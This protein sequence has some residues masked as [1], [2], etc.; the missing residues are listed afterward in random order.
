MFNPSNYSTAEQTPGNLV[1]TARGSSLFG[2]GWLIG[3]PLGALLIAFL[4]AGSVRRLY[5][6]N[7][8][9]YPSA[10]VESPDAKVRFFYR[11]FP[12]IGIGA[13]ALF[14]GIGYTSGSITLNR[15]TNTATMTGKMTAF[16]PAQHRTVALDSI[17][18]ATL[19]Q[20]PNSRRIRLEGTHGQD[21]AFPI[22]SDRA[23]QQEAVDAINRFLQNGSKERQP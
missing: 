21:L 8:V 3:I 18:D 16:L 10:T 1:V 5:A 15:S 12:A 11:L 2:P 23:G 22:W 17:T 13:A 20:K 14:Y 6:S 4:V 7:A 9:R 19:D